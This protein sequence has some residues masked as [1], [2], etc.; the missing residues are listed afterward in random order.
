M[1]KVGI[2]FIYMTLLNQK[3]L[4][5]QTNKTKHILFIDLQENQKI[6]RYHIFIYTQTEKFQL[7]ESQVRRV[8]AAAAVK[9]GL[10]ITQNY[11]S[12][13]WK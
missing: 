6:F 2:S 3:I 1:P 8:H 7:A 11:I 4:F 12:L 10:W 9:T 5:F 13:F